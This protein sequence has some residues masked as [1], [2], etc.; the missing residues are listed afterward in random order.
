MS[1]ATLNKPFN[2][3]EKLPHS[4]CVTL[5]HRNGRVGCGT[6]ER[7]VMTGRLLHWSA[8]VSNGASNSNAQSSVPPYVAVLDEAD[9]TTSSIEMLQTFSSNFVAGDDYGPVNDGGGP[10]R[11]ILVLST[12]PS[13]IDGVTF[14]SPEPF[15]PQ[16]EGTPMENL[17]VGSSY[18]WNVNNNGDG[19]TFTDM[20]GVPTVYIEDSQT[21]NYLRIVASEQANSISSDL[22]AAVYPSVL[23]EFNYYMGPSETTD[24]TKVTSQQCLG[25][26]DL[27]GNWSPKCLPLGGNSV[28]AAA[29]TPVTFGYTDNENANDNSQDRP[30]VILAASIDSTSMF[31]ELS[32]GA[33]TAASNILS[34]LLAAELLGSSIKDEVLDQLYSRIAFAFF[35]GE[36]YGFIGSRSFVKDVTGGFECQAGNEGVPSVMKRKDETSTTRACLN[37]LRTDLTFQNLGDIRGMIA[38]DQVGNLGGGKNLY[39]QG[40]ANAENGFDAFLSEV[41]IE[42]SANGEYTA[43]ASSAEDSLP[44]SPVSS[45]VQLSASGA[46]GVVLTGYDDAFVANSL[47]HSHLDSVSKSQSIDKDAIAASATLLA[48]SA[49]AAA[50]QNENN[51]VDAATAAAYAL[52]LLPNT[53][54]ASSTTFESLYNCLFSDGNCDTLIKYASVESANDAIRTGINLGIGQPLGKPPNYYVSVYNHENGQGFVAASGFK[55]GAMDSSAEDK[56]DYVKDYGEDENDTTLLRPSLLEMSL[57]GLLNDFLG[58]GSFADSNDETTPD[59]KAC[60]STN[61]CSKVSY[62]SS[63]D[64]NELA[65]ISTCAGGQCIC[66]SRAHYHPAL[67]EAI[68]PATNQAPGWFTIDENDQGVSAMIAEPFWSSFVGV[69]A[70]NDA[71][72][73]V[74]L[75]SSIAGAIFT[76]IC[77]IVVHRLKKSLV[78]DKVY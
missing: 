46:G 42:L 31:H 26:K 51:E 2:N 48:R 53:V 73:G 15:A 34:L 66:G 76:L 35:Q 69:R 4:P 67:D 59:L 43:Q 11:G 33:N 70:Y 23:S 18:E 6:L 44:P 58:R 50:Y 28:W 1:A 41:M 10:L 17:S 74:G 56:D 55:Y 24:G 32:P 19:L 71:G 75:F 13:S 12:D 49:V 36:S 5:Y 14:P 25:W 52:N 72:E 68:S 27:D 63:S 78:K 62:C 37:P 16:G 21:A 57:N 29:G 39:V 65:A 22:N 38:V 47:Y 40:G 30:T 20:A 45:L 61:D 7:E 54:S 60:S 64:S 9:Y 77:L 8:V 3:L